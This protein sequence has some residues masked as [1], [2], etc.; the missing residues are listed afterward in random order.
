M[1]TCIDI[2]EAPCFPSTETVYIKAGGLVS[3]GER[4]ITCVDGEPVVALRIN[5]NPAPA[6]AF[7][8]PTPQQVWV[9][10]QAAAAESGQVLPLPLPTV[11]TGT[12]TIDVDAPLPVEVQGTV[13]VSAAAPLTVEQVSVQEAFNHK[14][15]AT[16]A[17]AQAVTIPAG[18]FSW[19]AVLRS[20]SATSGPDLVP[21][22]VGIEGSIGN[23]ATGHNRTAAWTINVGPNSVLEYVYARPPT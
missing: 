23:V 3:V 1:N 9:V 10:N 13:A 21:M 5:G 20:G 2:R 22:V 15:V 12:Q 8:V 14:R 11:P 16:S 17:S 4:V 18:G 19:S 7:V 6:G